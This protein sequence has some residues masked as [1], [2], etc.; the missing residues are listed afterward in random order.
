M[1][2]NRDIYMCSKPL[3]YFNIRNTA[4]VKRENRKTLI[5]LDFFDDAKSFTDLVRTYDKTWDEVL[6]MRNKFEEY[7]YLLRHTCENLF[8]ELDASFI[9]GLLH[10]LGCY[11]RMYLFEEG[12]GSYRRDR[13]GNARGIKR[14]VNSLT[15]VSDRIGFSDFLTGQYLYLPELY[16]RQFPESTKQILPFEKDFVSRIKED[17]PLF[18][19]LSDGYDIFKTIERQKIAIYLTGHTVNPDI[20]EYMQSQRK[21]IDYL[22]VKPHPHLRDLSDFARYDM[23][24]VHPNIMIEFLLLLLLEN[25]NEITVYHENTTG[26]LWF[27]NKI[28]NCNMGKQYLE[29]EIVA[30]Y[31]R[32][33]ILCE[34]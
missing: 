33:N 9:L 27:Q 4:C 20:V 2:I 13:F 34:E 10:K 3:Q 12:Y 11:K 8:V 24:V 7:S 25:E 21:D 15:G 6:F 28:H 23:T 16:K 19:K 14:W 29:Y 5:I 30:S 31:I 22:F 1:K 26:V 32:D 18:L 17:L